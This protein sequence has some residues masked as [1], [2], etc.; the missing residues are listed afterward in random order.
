M[1]SV[2]QPPIDPT[3]TIEI[4]SSVYQVQWAGIVSTPATNVS[5]VSGTSGYIIVVVGL[6]A[7]NIDSTTTGSLQLIS[8]S[9]G[10]KI[11]QDK[12]VPGTN[13][14][15]LILTEKLSGYGKTSSGHALYANIA[16]ANCY[17]DVYYLKIP[18]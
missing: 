5:V 2:L 1:T 3:K 7:N 13:Q 17:A 16:T 15:P 18:G 9:G 6:I 4:G 10:S 12:N 14:L 8:N 11:M